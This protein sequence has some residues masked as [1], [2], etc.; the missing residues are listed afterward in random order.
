[1][2]EFRYVTTAIYQ[3][4]GTPNPV[5]AELPFTN[6][7][8]TQQLNSIGTF[9]GEVLISGINSVNQNVYGGTTP[10]QTMLWVLYADAYTNTT[11]PVWSGII[12]HREY[13][14]ST[15]IMQITAQEVMSLYQKRLITADRAYASQNPAAIAY[16]L[17]TYA[18]GKSP[19]G[20]TGLTYAAV[21]TI[22]SIPA[23]TYNGYQY[24]S[25]YQAIKDLAQNYFDFAIVP[26]NIGGVLSNK[27]IM[28]APLQGTYSATSPNASVFQFPG[29]VVEYRFPE[30]GSSAVNYLY[31]LG[32][33][34]NNT[35][36]VQPAYDP[37]KL[38]TGTWPLLEGSANYIDISNSTIL[39]SLAQGQTSAISYPPTTV[40]IVVPPYIDPIY[41]LYQIGQEVRVD[42]IDDY[43]PTG[44]HLI[45][46]IVGIS[47]QPGENSPSR[48]TLT[49]TRQLQAGIV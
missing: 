11:T 30:D 12:W 46:R 48:V 26:N 6:V 47:V 21:P 16:D 17:M 27:F 35:K 18:E 28:G 41:P 20:N 5:I 34:A 3:S 1:M 29:N 4:G 8:F 25:V 23:I 43:F 32:Y 42:I 10:A 33:G 7:H 40:E 44:L 22:S 39:K 36:I 49:L 45:M 38:T 14:S 19:H 2:S 9:Q 31:A 13:D 24:K 15:Q 37:D